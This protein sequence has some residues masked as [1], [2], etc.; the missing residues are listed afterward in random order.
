MK[1]ICYCSSALLLRQPL[2]K[3]FPLRGNVNTLTDTHTYRVN[4]S[5]MQPSATRSSCVAEGE[6]F[7]FPV[8][9]GLAV[10]CWSETKLVDRGLLWRSL[11]T[12][13]FQIICI[14]QLRLWKHFKHFL[15]IC[16]DWTC[17]EQLLSWK[18]KKSSTTS[19]ELP[20]LSGLVYNQIIK[21]G[22]GGGTHL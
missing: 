5:W 20:F 12:Y 9:T 7:S 17:S 4:S 2:A 13:A 6:C 3:L 22:G 21:Q 14:R 18:S 10:R 16:S 15:K 11:L 8:S 1:F 19:G